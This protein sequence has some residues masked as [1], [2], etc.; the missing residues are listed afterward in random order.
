MAIRANTGTVQGFYQDDPTSTSGISNA[1][2]Q[3]RAQNYRGTIQAPREYA[4]EYG[5]NWGKATSVLQ[6][7]FGGISDPTLD[8]RGGIQAEAQKRLAGLENNS[9][10]N[11]AALGTNL[12]QSFANNIAQARR[13]AAGTGAGA[14]LGYGRNVGALTNDAQNQQAQA[15]LNVENQGYSQL[16]QIGNL[17]NQIF[18]QEINANQQQADQAKALANMY[19]M[20]ANKESGRQDAVTEQSNA[21]TEARKAAQA[22]LLQSIGQTIGYHA[23]GQSGQDQMQGASSMMN[24]GGGG[25]GGGGAAGMASMAAMFSDKNLKENITEANGDMRDFLDSLSA[26]KYNYKNPTHGVG[27]AFSVMAQDLQKTSVGNSMVI[28]TPEGLM[29]DYGRGFGVLLASQVSLNDRLNGIENMLASILRK[30]GN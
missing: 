6:G 25:G 16:G 27:E 29:V 18:G 30:M 10:Q 4:D 15:M 1:S 19:M 8:L 9:A 22:A 2:S 7:G 14:S 13:G 21:E 24:S 12:E 5:K 23:S 17:N 3:A 20:M 28:K 11:K 26:N